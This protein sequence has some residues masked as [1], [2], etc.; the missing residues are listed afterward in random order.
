MNNESISF[1]KELAENACHFGHKTSKWHPKMKDFIWGAKGGIHI[2]D[3]EKTA[4]YLKEILNTV[5]KISESGKTILFVSTKPQTKAIMKEIKDKKDYPV[6]SNKWI[7]GLLT[8][9]YTIK[10]RIRRLKEIREMIQTDD[11]SKF[12]KKEKSKILKEGEK[13]EGV[14]GGIDNMYKL[15]DAIFV[16]DGSRDNLAIEEA[17]KLSIPI[18]GIADTNVNPDDYEKLVPANDDAITSVTFLLGKVFESL[19]KRKVKKT[20]HRGS[21]N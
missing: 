21:R 12:T 11:I 19:E 1:I 6:I 18:Y 4:E 2:I 20:F 15:P 14:F 8:N 5:K 3:L 9:F 10:N 7:G 16:V 17:K 13:L